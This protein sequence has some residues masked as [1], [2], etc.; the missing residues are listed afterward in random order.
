MY[1]G[2]IPGFLF[3]VCKCFRIAEHAERQR[4]YKQAAFLVFVVVSVI[5][6]ERGAGPVHHEFVAGLMTYVHRQSVL[7]DIVRIQ[8]TEL[9]IHVRR[10]P[11]LSALITVLIPQRTKSDTVFEKFFVYPFKV[12]RDLNWDQF[13]LGKEKLNDFRLF[14]L[15]TLRKWLATSY[16]CC[17]NE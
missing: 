10:P 1:M 15:Q 8:F 11:G 14:H 3:H 13:L 2:I 9:R 6:R 5:V 16:R 17:Y 12:W 7:I 4:S